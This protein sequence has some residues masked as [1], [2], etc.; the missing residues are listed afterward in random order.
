LLQAATGQL[1]LTSNRESIEKVIANPAITPAV[2]KRLQ[3]VVEARAFASKELG[4]PDNQTY[5]TY[6]DLK[7]D[8]VVWNVYATDRFSVEPRRWCFPV[9]GCVVYRG[10]FKEEAAQKYA[11]RTRLDGGDATVSGAAAY[12]TL[13]HFDDPVLSSMLRWNDSQMVATLFH[14]LAHQVFY[15]PNESGFNEAFA[16]VVEEA[17]LKRWLAIHGDTISFE[18]KQTSRARSQAVTSLLLSTRDR[19]RELYASEPPSF[20]LYIRKQREFGRLKFEYG[21]LKQN[22]NGYSGY[23]AWFNGTLSNADLISAATYESCAPKL[24]E[25]LESVGNDLP[26]FYDAVKRLEPAERKKLC[27]ERESVNR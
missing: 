22:W 15:V 17:G 3:L 25:I 5:R 12:S 8:Y 26:K 7:R 16:S 21:Q 13:G 10:Y 24:E 14:E 19:L 6:V 2:Q 9:A 23:D 18:A 4:L 27:A 20:D 1:S 11:R